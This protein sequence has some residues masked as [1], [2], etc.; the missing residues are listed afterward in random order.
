MED[1]K[2]RVGLITDICTYIKN[3]IILF[4]TYFIKLKERAQNLGEGSVFK[5]P[6]VQI[7]VLE[8]KEWI[9]VDK[10]KII[11]KMVNYTIGV[12]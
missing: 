2:I 12:S 9:V 8:P 7:K 10:N 3:N 4:C 6:S 11:D 5:K 1:V